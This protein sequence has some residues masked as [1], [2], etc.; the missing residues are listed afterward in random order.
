[1]HPLL[2]RPQGDKRSVATAHNLLLVL[3]FVWKHQRK[4]LGSLHPNIP[5]KIKNQP[6]P[7][8]SSSIPVA[9]NGQGSLT[10]HDRQGEVGE[11]CGVSCELS[12]DGNGCQSNPGQNGDG[13]HP[14]QNESE[15]N[16]GPT[17]IQGN[18]NTAGVVTEQPEKAG[19]AFVMNPFITYRMLLEDYRQYYQPPDEHGD[20]P[21]CEKTLAIHESNIKSFMKQPA[22]TCSVIPRQPPT[23]EFRDLGLGKLELVQNQEDC[24]FCQF[25]CYYG[26]SKAEVLSPTSATWHRCKDCQEPSI[27]SDELDFILESHSFT[28]PE[29]CY[30][31]DEDFPF[32]QVRDWSTYVESELPSGSSVPGEQSGYDGFQ[33]VFSDDGVVPGEQS[34]CAGFQQVSSDNGV[35]EN[36]EMITCA[37]PVQPLLSERFVFRK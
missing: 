26:T 19:Q 9:A 1:M 15:Q 32:E 4:V 23:P 7:R 25:Q 24:S 20:I 36:R 29:G 30:G 21:R 37:Q 31:D 33:Q 18:G 6:S 22:E 16:F 17:S 8:P 11:V 35:N 27:F 34:K 3:M 28:E 2:P 13:S 14:T 5:V 12:D 10:S